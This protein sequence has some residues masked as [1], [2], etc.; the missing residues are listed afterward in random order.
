MTAKSKSIAPRRRPAQA[1]SKRKVEWLLEAAARVF[2]AE[3]YE[4]TTNRIAKVAGVSIGT[5]YEYFPNK[6]ALLLALA[7]Q[8]VA[9]AESGIGTALK[10]RDPLQMLPL[11]QEAVLASQRYPSTAI[12]F[13]ADPRDQARLQRRVAALRKQI[14]S[15]LEA[16][17][18]T[19]GSKQPKLHARIAFG[20]VGELTST[21]YYEPALT[22]QHEQL[23]HELLELALAHF[24]QWVPS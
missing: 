22:A 7:E 3:G 20:L 5:L 16:R 8:H 19:A 2:R 10:E 11:L 23:A 14:L 17:A 1:R 21:T 12:A 9:E 24:T 4:A 13:V 18:K 15:T 6:D